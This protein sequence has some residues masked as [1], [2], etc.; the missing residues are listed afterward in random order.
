MMYL[1]EIFFKKVRLAF[2]V[3]MAVLP[4]VMSIG[5]SGCTSG[6]SGP[7]SGGPADIPGCTDRDGDG[8]YAEEGCGKRLDCADRDSTIHPGAREYCVGIDNDCDGLVDE[9]CLEEICGDG[10]D[11]DGDGVIDEE[12]RQ[13][14]SFVSDTGQTRCYNTMEFLYPCPSPGEAFYGQD[15]CYSTNSTPFTKLDAGGAPLTKDATYWTMVQ[16]NVTGLIWEVKTDDESVHDRDLISDWNDAGSVLITQMNDEHYGGFSDWRLPTIYELNSIVDLIGRDPSISPDYFPNT[17]TYSYWSGT[18]D[19]ADAGNAWVLDFLDGS[20]IVQAKSKQFCFRAVR[21]K[22]IT[23]NFTDNGDGTVTTGFNGKY[24]MWAKASSTEAMTWGEALAYCEDLSLAGYSDWR[25]PNIKEL[26][27]IVDYEN[28]HP[29]T[30]VNYFPKEDDLVCYH[31]T[32]WASTTYARNDNLAWY[33]HL[34]NGGSRGGLEKTYLYD[35]SLV[36]AVRGGL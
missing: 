21:G 35:K 30:N 27:A 3:T 11:N 23:L 17:M 28:H 12:C 19:A 26:R 16:D 25:L 9:D 6:S 36:R 2:F 22:K 31:Y 34:D 10:A 8:F 33:V 7:G 32:F 13:G 15:A 18:T 5:I 20:V 24:L 4:L 14:T 29:A 1:P